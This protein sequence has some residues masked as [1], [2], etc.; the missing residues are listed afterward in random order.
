MRR[1]TITLA[2]LAG[3]VAAVAAGCGS[4]QA[5]AP[6]AWQDRLAGPLADIEIIDRDS[7]E[8]LPIYQHDGRHYVAGVPGRRYAV[9]VTN[10]SGARVLTVIAV[11]GVNAVSGETAAW[12]QSGYVLH[13]WQRYEVRGWRKSRERVAAFEFTALP[14]SY[15]ARTGRPDDVGV[16][17]V[18]VFRE[19]VPPPPHQPLAPS[20]SSSSSAAPQ[21]ALPSG[22][23]ATAP[24]PAAVP[25]A[26]AAAAE[27]SEARRGEA[28][29]ALARQDRLGTGH[30]QSESSRVSTT[31][32]ER[33]TPQPEQVVTVF[34]D[35]HANLVAAGVIPPWVAPWVAQAPRTPQPFPGSAGFVPDPPRR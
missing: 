4:V 3:A 22:D 5:H 18:A 31:A 32:F 13:P 24:A 27:R 17:G 25:S 2:A 34:Y 10:R 19:R 6:G 33:A 8:R 28:S 20:S 12:Q 26:P 21:R 7:G 16:I 30:G 1:R 9:A 23:A 15:A 35:S 11:D 29:G 14:D